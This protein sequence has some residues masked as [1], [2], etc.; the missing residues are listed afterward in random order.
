MSQLEKVRQ[1]DEF[2]VCFHN[3]CVTMTD[4]VNVAGVDS[5]ANF[6]KCWSECYHQ[7]RNDAQ[8]KWRFRMKL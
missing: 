2:I 4:K 7:A 5:I 1:I 8:N 6:I 3:A